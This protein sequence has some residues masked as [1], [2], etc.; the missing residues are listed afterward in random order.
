M[1]HWKPDLLVCTYCALWSKM[2]DLSQ[3]A[4]WIVP[5]NYST[6]IRQCLQLHKITCSTILDI[7]KKSTYLKIIFLKLLQVHL[8]GDLYKTLTS[9]NREGSSLVLACW[10]LNHIKYCSL[11]FPNSILTRCHANN[12]ISGNFTGRQVQWTLCHYIISRIFHTTP[13]HIITKT[14]ERNIGSAVGKFSN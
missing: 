12:S 6:L 13:S 11:N 1:P 2:F 7:F 4:T 10:T 3:R 9:K 5:L 8:Q 14:S